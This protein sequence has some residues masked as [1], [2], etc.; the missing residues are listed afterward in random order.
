[1]I[2]RTEQTGLLPIQA[3]HF[4]PSKD[5]LSIILCWW[6]RKY[7]LG[8]TVLERLETG[9]RGAKKALWADPQPVP[10]GEWRKQNK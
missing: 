5:I 2:V 7:A 6:Y 4:V 3:K 8:D 10:Q 1:V 9:V